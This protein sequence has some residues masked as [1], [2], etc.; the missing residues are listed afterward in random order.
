[1]ASR[2]EAAINETESKKGEG[3]HDQKQS[4]GFPTWNRLRSQCLSACGLLSHNAAISI[5]L[6]NLSRG[7]VP[8]RAYRSTKLLSPD[9]EFIR[10]IATWH[11][12]PST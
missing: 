9:F 10:K 3:L 8:S 6:T 11:Q 7:I 12:G 5:R 4:S 2:R 1:M